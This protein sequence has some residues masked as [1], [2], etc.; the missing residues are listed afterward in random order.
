MFSHLSEKKNLFPLYSAVITA[1]IFLIILALNNICGFGNNTILSGDL[2]SQYSAFIQSFINTIKG[3]GSFYYSFSI[4]L[5]NPATASYAYYCLSPFNLLYLP[6]IIS[7]S[8]MTL[9]IIMLKLSLSAAAF[10]FWLTRG[11]KEKSPFTILFG[12][13]YA[14]CGFAV[15]MFVHI[16]WQD[17]LYTLPI[18]LLLILRFVKGGSFLP[19]IPAYAYLFLTNFYMGY[20]AGI[21]SAL[22]FVA[23]LILQ[24][25]KWEKAEVIKAVKRGLLYAFSVLLG[26]ACCAAVL[27]PT[28]FELFNKDS[29]R[30]SFALQSVT[31]PDVINNL[32]LGEMQGMG[33]PIPLIYCGLPVLLL[34]FI[35]FTCRSISKKEK[36][37]S[38]FLLLFYLAAT[39]FLPLYQFLHAM[40]APNWYAHRYAYCIV[41][42]LLSVSCRA[43]PYIREVKT[44]TL[45]GYTAG[46]LLMYTILIPIQDLCY[47]SYYTNTHGWLILNAVF[48]SLYLLLMHFRPKR[49]ALFITVLFTA[50]VLINGYTCVSRND[51]GFHSEEMVEQWENTEEATIPALL[52][53]DP[54]FYRV[55]VNGEVCFNA[56]S[57][58][59]YA[60]IN[61]FTTTDN[62]KL[63]ET[64]S[65]LG[66]ATSFMSIYDHGYTDIT[67]M[68]FGVKYSLDLGS[69]ELSG[70]PLALPLG[71]M[72]SASLMAWENSEDVFTN[73]ENL[74]S[75]MCNYPY[76][77]YTPVSIDE[78]NMV[79]RNMEILPFESAILFQHISDMVAN[80]V[81]RFRFPELAG[82]VILA[83]FP[84][85]EEPVIRSTSPEADLPVTGFSKSI[86]LSDGSIFCST[87]DENNI[88]EVG[89]VFHDGPDYDYAVGAIQLR[90]YDNSSLTELHNDL[91][92]Q[93]LSIE[94]YEDGYISGTVEAT[95]DRPLL[96][97]SIPY[98]EGWEALVDGA[99]APV[100][101]VVNDSFSGLYLTPGVHKIILQYN[102]PGASAGNI[103]SAVAVILFLI[104]LLMDSKKKTAA[105]PKVSDKASD[106][107][108][109]QKEESKGAEA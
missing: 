33:S 101:S 35:Y 69:G 97:L 45:A 9:V 80:G 75:L 41:F 43:L 79:T 90:D 46:L 56:P 59:H 7:V 49:A 14:L 4:F 68:I 99:P 31:I 11:L 84:T 21:F 36:L 103:I 66:I 3:N 26:A 53:A 44:K 51:F 102:H 16:M 27:L 50:E 104:L 1:V 34:V 87:W 91:C 70:S 25:D 52:A 85:V 98:D 106:E 108:S 89:L 67:D 20:I 93:P 92:R 88:P 30:S 81:I 29:S 54:S 6:G 12:T 109:A 74:V 17:A 13:A 65:S 37:L 96:F 107:D 73:Q 78:E 32:F 15:S 47:P 48:L 8:A 83:H 61:S 2:F 42:V 82:H 19:L 18:L 60:G 23:L 72:C 71:Y 55:R 28:A 10:Q 22:C 58:F 105:N 94:S 64:L 62:A 38:G 63:R 100:L 76:T 24:I 5:G 95:E 39:Q 40:E 86:N 57:R 77:L